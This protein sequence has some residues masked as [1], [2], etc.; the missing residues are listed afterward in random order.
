M[1][2]ELATVKKAAKKEAE[3]SAAIMKSLQER[4][5][6]LHKEIESIGVAFQRALY[7]QKE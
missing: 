1:E 4:V 6:P 2:K 7:L 3:S 5:N